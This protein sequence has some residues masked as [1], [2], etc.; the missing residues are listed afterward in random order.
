MNQPSIHEQLSHFENLHTSGMSYE[1]LRGILL[2][3]ILGKELPAILYWSGKNLARKYPL[4][5]GEEI[6]QFF[7]QMG[8]GTLSVV[9]EKKNH[10]EFELTSEFIAARNKSRK[11]ASYQLESGFLAQQYEQM[12]NVIAEAYEDQKKRS[13]KVFITVKWDHKDSIE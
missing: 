1:L 13:N 10:L 12:K 5:K 7:E 8:W 6:I 4:S 9:S 3:E 2:P 11:P